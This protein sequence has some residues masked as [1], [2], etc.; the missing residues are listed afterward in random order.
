MAKKKSLLDGILPDAPAK[1]SDGKK[2]WRS[3]RELHI[4]ALEAKAALTPKEKE[5]L[6]QLKD[7]K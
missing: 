3:L 5:L 2:R 1:K 4:A 6:G 7:R